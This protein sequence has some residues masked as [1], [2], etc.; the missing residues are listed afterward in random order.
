MQLAVSRKR[1]YLADATGALLTRYPDGLASALAKISGHAHPMQSASH[2]TAHLFIS[3][4][5]AGAAPSL[6]Q[7]LGSFFATHP[8][9]AERIRRLREMDM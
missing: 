8:P 7:K 2:A 1:E 9:A 5:F 6:W 3:D 4:P